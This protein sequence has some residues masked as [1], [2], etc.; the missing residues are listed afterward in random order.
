M[1]MQEAVV[2]VRE[3]EEER[4]KSPPPAKLGC[5]LALCAVVA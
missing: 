3:R 1:F 2:S 4:M 5:S